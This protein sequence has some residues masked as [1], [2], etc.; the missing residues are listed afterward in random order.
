[1]LHDKP[2][3]WLRRRPILHTT[4]SHTNTKKAMGNNEKDIVFLLF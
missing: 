3:Q 1:M 4:G 2:K